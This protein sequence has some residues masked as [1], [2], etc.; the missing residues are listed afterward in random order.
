MHEGEPDKVNGIEKELIV[1]E[2][3]QRYN[4]YRWED[5][6]R[7]KFINF[8]MIFYLGFFGLIGYLMEHE[9]V[10]KQ[11]GGCHKAQ[12]AVIFLIGA[13]I[14]TLWLIAIIRFRR[15]QRIEMKTI[16]QIKKEKSQYLY[17]LKVPVDIIK[18]GTKK[19]FFFS[20]T[21]L[22]IVIFLLNIIMIIL[23]CRFFRWTCYLSDA[24]C[25]CILFG[26]VIVYFATIVLST[27]VWPPEWM[28]LAELD[29]ETNKGGGNLKDDENT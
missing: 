18:I 16:C 4:Q 17:E 1:Q 10:L 8:Y 19:A 2:F 7:S 15:V 27:W 5:E 23:S 22:V 13:V 21:P 12:Y 11:F 29:P 6:T 24:W 9:D 26:A 20:T 25:K 14:G 3:V 28:S